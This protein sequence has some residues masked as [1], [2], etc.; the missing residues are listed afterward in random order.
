MRYIPATDTDLDTMLSDSGAGSLEKI[1][2]QVPANIREKAKL[3]LPPA[4]DE[5]S[6]MRHMKSL[7]DQNAHMDDRPTFL[8]AGTYNHFIPSAVGHILS[9][10]EFFTAYTAA[11]LQTEIE[12]AC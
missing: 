11:I 10:A 2:S 4:L 8:G 12:A 5:L 1:L 9:R 6:L 3:D 7:S